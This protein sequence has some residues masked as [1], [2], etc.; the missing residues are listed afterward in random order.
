MWP[1]DVW[2]PPHF[3]TCS[4]L[5]QL[6]LHSLNSDSIR[7]LPVPPFSNPIGSLFCRISLCSLSME[8]ILTGH[9]GFFQHLPGFGYSR[10]IVFISH[11]MGPIPICLFSLLFGSCTSEPVQSSGWLGDTFHA[12][13]S[14]QSSFLVIG[15]Q[16]SSMR[17]NFH[18]ARN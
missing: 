14:V 4:T 12:W 3:P 1:L 7:H 17:S 11:F 2:T 8:G 15:Q 13:R 18:P 10:L 5:F 6:K 9:L 16:F